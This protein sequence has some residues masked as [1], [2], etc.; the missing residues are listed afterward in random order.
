LFQLT[1]AGQLFGAAGLEAPQVCQKVLEFDASAVPHAVRSRRSL[2]RFVLGATG[3]RGRSLAAR[4]GGDAG[5]SGGVVQAGKPEPPRIQPPAR[6]VIGEDGGADEAGEE[7]ARGH[8]GGALVPA[9]G[10]GDA[11]VL[12]SV[13]LPANA[14]D[15]GSGAE[16]ASVDKVF[17]VLL[18]PQDK[19]ATYSCALPRP[20]ML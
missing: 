16:L 19:Y 14:S 6:V 1:S 18:H 9:G 7:H 12:V 2:E 3:F 4:G 10:S 20:V 15:G 11:P 17:V 5:G 13:L 8:S